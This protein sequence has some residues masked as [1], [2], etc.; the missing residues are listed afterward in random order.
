MDSINFTKNNNYNNNLYYIFGKN[1]LY[2]KISLPFIPKKNILKKNKSNIG[3]YL[4]NLQ[5]KKKRSFSAMCSYSQISNNPNINQSYYIN[6]I[7]FKNNEKINDK[8]YNNNMNPYSICWIKNIVKKRK[9]HKIVL[10]N[11]N[12]SV[13]EIKLKIQ[14]KV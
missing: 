8:E 11:N 3:D 7:N 5:S 1:H 13:P 2:K 12:L 14:K 10:K 6:Y 4:N 9:N